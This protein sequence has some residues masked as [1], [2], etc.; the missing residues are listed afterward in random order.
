MK[1]NGENTGMADNKL[2][3]EIKTH[4]ASL[5]FGDLI[6][7]LLKKIGPLYQIDGIA[8]ILYDEDLTRNDVIYV[9][10]TDKRTSEI[11]SHYLA[12]QKG[13]NNI[14]KEIA[15]FQ[16]P[17]IKSRKEWFDEF[18][19]NHCINNNADTYTHHCYIPLETDN[20]ILGTLSIHNLVKELSS[21]GLVFC[22]N[23][24]D[25][26]AEAI[27]LTKAK[28]FQPLAP[29]MIRDNHSC[30]GN[31][32]LKTDQENEVL[33]ALNSALAT[34]KRRERDKAILLSLS[35]DLSKARNK[36]D[37]N[38]ILHKRI[39]QVL[40]FEQLI[41]S[42]VSADKKT[43]SIYFYTIK[44]A[45]DPGAKKVIAPGVYS[46]DDYLF[47]RL[48]ETEEPLIFN[49]DELVNNNIV[50][51]IGFEHTNGIG[52]VIAIPL[53]SGKERHGMMLIAIKER[54]LFGKEDIDLLKG[55]GG[56]ISIA[57][58]NVLA[59]EQINRQLDEI[60]AYKEKLEEEQVYRLDEITEPGNYT[61]I[62]G[63]G[64]EM[65]TVFNLLS[66]VAD[67]ETTVLILGETGTGKELIARAL[68][69]NSKRR[70]KP[71]IK[72]NCA[73]IPANLIE[74]ELFGH[75]KGSFTGAT[76]RRIGKF[77]LANNSTLFLDEI[78][79]LPIEL[80]V[81]LLRVLQ[82][83]EFE[84]VGGR[85]ILR[86]DVR[87]I[88][89]TNR[90][91][92]EEIEAGNFRRDLFYRL[93][94]FPIKLPSLRERI[95]DLPVLADYFLS[96][97]SRKTGKNID[98]FSNKAIQ[99]LKSYHW[100]G[101]VRELEH[102]IERHVLL[103]KGQIISEIKIP[104]AQK[105]TV[106]ASGESTALKTLFENE[107]DYIFSVLQH[108]NGRVSG[109]DGA[110]KILGVPATTLNSKI[111]KLGLIKSHSV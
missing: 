34:A 90:S 97:Y 17:V 110:A 69:N 32:L 16:F 91:L 105:V 79:E 58:T 80:Q 39:G 20:K 53:L 5:E 35:S 61:D 65:K 27:S 67:S 87:I 49:A 52:L 23:I 33:L 8:L 75:E 2:I 42:V 102:L 78:G 66:Q 54:K 12:E 31:H 83:K 88:S 14:S 85:T 40:H 111:K 46:T 71:M 100:P 24:A 103:T 56:Q 89:A 25:I 4:L 41:V 96:I 22:S 68:H 57:I 81:K 101:N 37:I 38:F 63:N 108:C 21:E 19:E 13:F 59:Y 109:S 18:G 30:N 1:K 92:Q 82:E 60:N 104:S 50:G 86:T 51:Y 106:S 10:E 107:R 29:K 99:N 77:E 62:I 36:D 55:I 73:A 84:R 48:K 47:T 44:D 93:N 64:P 26:L 7:I 28:S 9:S 74:S 72:V 70:H 6:H 76:E 94:V 11:I 95:N 3:K 15:G 45:K 43:H 98:G